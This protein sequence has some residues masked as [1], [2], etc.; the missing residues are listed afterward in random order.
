M[1][2]V[3]SDTESCIVRQFEKMV[4]LSESEVNL[5]AALERDARKFELW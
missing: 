4:E 2:S 5:L 1:E 3:I